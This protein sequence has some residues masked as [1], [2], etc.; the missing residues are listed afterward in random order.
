M[1]ASVIEGVIFRKKFSIPGH[2]YMRRGYVLQHEIRHWLSSLRG[3]RQE[4]G[5]RNRN[6]TDLPCNLEAIN[7]LFDLQVSHVTK[8]ITMSSQHWEMVT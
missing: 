2:R 5:A 6:T 8:E 3:Q 4:E 1:D 7:N